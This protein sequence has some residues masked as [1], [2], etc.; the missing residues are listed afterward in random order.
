L[1]N[2]GYAQESEFIDEMVNLMVTMDLEQV[3][4]ERLN[5]IIKESRVNQNAYW[6]PFVFMAL[7]QRADMIEQYNV[8]QEA[9]DYNRDPLLWIYLAKHSRLAGLDQYASEA[10]RSLRGW[11][12][13]ATLEA[14]QIK[15][16]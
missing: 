9:T 5:K 2:E 10:L 12:D 8:L 16:M 7:D 15:H 1:K 4:N 13:D 11:V 3:N 14:L 6:T